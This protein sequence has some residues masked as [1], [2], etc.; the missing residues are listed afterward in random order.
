MSTGHRQRL[1]RRFWQT[2][3]RYRFRLF[4]RHRHNRLVLEWV[5]ARPFLIL[6]EVFNPTLFFT[7]DFMVRSLNEQLIPPGS[8]VLDLGTGSGVGAVFAAQLAA[9]QVVAVDINPTAV[10]CARINVMLNELEN[11]VEVRQG[12]LFTAVPGEKFDVILFNPP[13]FQG[14]PQDMLDRAFHATGVIERFAAESAGHLNPGGSV[15]L[16]SSSLTA[17]DAIL[18][19]FQAQG[20]TPQMVAQQNLRGETLWLHRL[21]NLQNR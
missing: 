19:L 15:L 10:R 9:R 1:N 5:A 20:F 21:E 13:Y 6:P 16:V 2:W 4:Q 3:R 14:E 12:D 17:V 7:S 11:C 18:H 8:R